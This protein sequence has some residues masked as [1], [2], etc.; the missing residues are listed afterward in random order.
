MKVLLVNGSSRNNGCTNV[1]LNEVIRAL[2][3]KN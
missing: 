2:N 1:A 3:E